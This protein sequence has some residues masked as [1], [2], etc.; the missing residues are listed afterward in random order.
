MFIADDIFD[1][2]VSERLYFGFGMHTLFLICLE[3]RFLFVAELYEYVLYIEIVVVRSIQ[4]VFGRACR[5]LVVSRGIRIRNLLRSDKR[6]VTRKD[7]FL[8]HALAVLDIFLHFRKLSRLAR[9]LAPKKF[10]DIRSVAFAFLR[11]EF[12]VV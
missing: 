10:D 5:R 8:G 7:L 6:I 3:L 9:L 1:K 4:H 2:I 12:G 11:V